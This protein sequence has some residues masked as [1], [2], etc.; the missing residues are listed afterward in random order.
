MEPDVGGSSV[1]IYKPIS[2]LIS[3]PLRPLFLHL[4]LRSLSNM[5][6]TFVYFAVPHLTI[7]ILWK[8]L[9]YPAWFSPLRHLPVPPG[10]N[11]V[12]GHALTIRNTRWRGEAAREWMEDTPNDGL[13]RVKNLFQGDAIIPTSPAMLK[14]ILNDNC[15]D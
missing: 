14:T 8:F 9:I 10:A 1:R 2:P 7:Y 3:I 4:T 11:I 13:L 5:V 12:F 15:Y 6:A